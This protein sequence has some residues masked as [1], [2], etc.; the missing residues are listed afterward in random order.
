VLQTYKF[1]TDKIEIYEN[2]NLITTAIRKT[3][4]RNERVKYTNA[5]GV[6]LGGTLFIPVKSNGKAIVLVH[7]AGSENRN[8]YAS[9]L[10]LLA[11]HLAREGVT[12]LTYDKQGIGESEGASYEKLNYAVV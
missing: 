6:I 2:G 8:G 7:G 3:F 5:K 9:N 10:R 12:V 1:K 4:Y 11:D